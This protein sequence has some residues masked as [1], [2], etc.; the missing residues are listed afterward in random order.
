MGIDGG[1]GNIWRFPYVVGESGGGVFLTMYI[2]LYARIPLIKCTVLG[3]N[4]A[5]TSNQRTLSTAIL[6]LATVFVVAAL[7]HAQDEDQKPTLKLDRIASSPAFLG[8]T[9]APM[10]EK[11]SYSVETVV[12]GLTTPWALAFLPASEILINEYSGSMRI[13]R[14]DGTLSDPLSGL[15]ELSHEGWAGLFDVALDPDFARNQL[16]YFSYTAPSGDPDSPNIPRV[17][18]GRLDREQLCLA[19]VEVIVDGAGWQELHFAP[20]GKLLV[21]GTGAGEAQ[22]LAVTSGKLLRINS[23]G[24]VPD[25]NPFVDVVGVRPEIFSY[26]HRDISGFATHPDTDEIWITEHGP[27]G[28]DELNVIRAGANYGWQVIS[29]GTQYSGK[30][31]GQGQTTHGAMEQPRYFWRPSIAPSGLI[32]YT[33]KMFPEWE[34][35]VFVTSLSGQ[36]ITRL[37][38]DGDRVIAEERLLV[39]RSE[40]IREL[41]EGA[42]GALYALTNEEGDAPK[43]TAELLRISK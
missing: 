19:D 27:R 9:R 30:P 5:M 23:D 24:S 26:G 1:L 15:P 20:D 42:D 4:K 7:A 12:G 13:L 32:F 22:E 10:A 34:G 17:A 36:H 39:D 3:G 21:S 35:N 37:V 18:R 6:S 33:G 16:V 2:Q 14:A 40:R 41:R 31:V 38:L 11:S 28:G 29:Y 25:D 8:Q 43:G